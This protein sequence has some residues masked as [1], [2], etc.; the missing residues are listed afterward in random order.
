MCF[1]VAG[2]A[3]GSGDAS[4]SFN[5][6]TVTVSDGSTNGDDPT[7]G[8]SSTTDSLTTSIS[9][10]GGESDSD[11]G[12]TS[13]ST[14]GPG[15]SDDTGSE[16]STS[17]PVSAEGTDSSTTDPSTTD[18]STSGTSTGPGEDTNPTTGGQQGGQPDSGMWSHCTM[19][20]NTCNGA[21]NICVHTDDDGYCTDDGC[22]NPN[23]DC[24]PVPVDSNAPPMCAE[25]IDANM[26]PVFFCAIDCSGG[27]TCPAG[28]VCT[29]N[30]TFGQGLPVYDI[31]M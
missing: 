11:A 30:L 18:P 10:E 14:S 21:A 7:D 31:C 2:C 26:N 13:P 23:V 15:T 24:D 3:A 25:A 29:P 22:V 4:T 19:Q 8:T 20:N 28:M 27:Q 16:G 1:A 12:T 6:V 5:P 9:A 17:S